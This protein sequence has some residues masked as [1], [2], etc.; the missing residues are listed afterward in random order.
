MK[1][2]QF[3]GTLTMK[4]GSGIRVSLAV[5]LYEDDGVYYAMCPAL[6]IIGYGNNEDEAKTSFEVMIAEVIKEVVENGNLF[7]WLQSLG[8]SKCQPPKT[9]EL[10]N[11]D[12]SL[13]TIVN[14][15]SYRTIHKDILLPC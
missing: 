3:E 9:T 8:W 12:E 4:E 7:V 5:F 2:A 15:K 6:D 13:A 1:Q 11:K 10:I 14:E